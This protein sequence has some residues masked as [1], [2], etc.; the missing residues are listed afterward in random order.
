MKHKKIRSLKVRIYIVGAFFLP[1]DLGLPYLE[2]SI[3]ATYRDIILSINLNP[4][5]LA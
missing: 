4:A 3:K 1:I 5:V 2:E